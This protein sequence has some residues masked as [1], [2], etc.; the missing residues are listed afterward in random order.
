MKFTFFTIFAMLPMSVI[1][2]GH[3]LGAIT[4]GP[5]PFFLIDEMRD[6]SVK[7]KLGKFRI[8]MSC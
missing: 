6:N 7:T 3:T 8:Y 5:R 1:G 2:N 4:L